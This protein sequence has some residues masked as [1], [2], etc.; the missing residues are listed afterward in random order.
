MRNVRVP[1][2]GTVTSHVSG[3][4]ADSADDVRCEVTLFGTVILAM[5]DSTAILTN[6]VFI[7]TKSTVK[8]C[9]FSKLVTLVVVLTLRRGS[10]LTT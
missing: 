2:N 4:T 6:L 9:K 1:V 5:T 7:V 10:G 3:T 8:S